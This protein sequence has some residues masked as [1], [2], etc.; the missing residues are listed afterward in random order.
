[1]Y[2]RVKESKTREIKGKPFY[3][4][5]GGLYLLI[6]ENKGSLGSS[7]IF[8]NSIPQKKSPSIRWTHAVRAR[9]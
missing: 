2:V 9:H 7:P 1:M 3:H 4:I 6:T 5:A 8:V